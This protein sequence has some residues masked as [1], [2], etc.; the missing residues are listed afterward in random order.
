MKTC[1][2]IG[3]VVECNSDIYSITVLKYKSEVRALILSAFP[4]VLLYTST[5]PQFRGI[6]CSFYFITFMTALVTS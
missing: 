5:P 3:T 1:K 6:Y 4:F 2:A